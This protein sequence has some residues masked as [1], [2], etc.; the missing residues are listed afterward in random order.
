MSD[1]EK[2]NTEL[3]EKAQKAFADC[4]AMEF[5][6]GLPV[7]RCENFPPF[8][9]YAEFSVTLNTE[10]INGLLHEEILGLAKVAADNDGK[11]W[12]DGREGRGNLAIVW[13]AS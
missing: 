6:N 10:P 12:L 9:A 7:L 11:L 3:L 4:L 1:T 8:M 2:K 5:Q 13:A